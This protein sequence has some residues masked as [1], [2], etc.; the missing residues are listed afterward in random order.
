MEEQKIYATNLTDGP[1]K[2]TLLNLS[3]SNCGLTPYYKLSNPHLGHFRQPEIELKGW[4]MINLKNY[5]PICAR[6]IKIKKI[7]NGK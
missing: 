3:C 6:T 5:C 2:T 4:E 1:Y 7:L